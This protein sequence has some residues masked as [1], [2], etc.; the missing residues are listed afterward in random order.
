MLNIG[1]GG[2]VRVSHSKLDLVLHLLRSG[3]TGKVS[4]SDIT[5]SG[6]GSLLASSLFQAE[7]DRVG[8]LSMDGD[9]AGK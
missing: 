8:S 4:Q 2:N 3:A 6:S 7:Y 1:P 9:S 5:M